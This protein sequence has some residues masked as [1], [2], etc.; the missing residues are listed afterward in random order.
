MTFSSV[1][2]VF[3]VNSNCYKQ[4]FVNIYTLLLIIWAPFVLFYYVGCVRLK[5][6][7]LGNMQSA[8]TSC[9]FKYN[10]LLFREWWH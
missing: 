10:F 9:D 2:Q 1:L 4:S 7:W 6:G 5:F 8:S 3:L